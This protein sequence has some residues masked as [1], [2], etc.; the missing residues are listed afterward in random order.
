VDATP[1]AVLVLADEL[2]LLGVHAHHRTV[3]VLV[4]AHLPG[5]VVE[6]GV[7]VRVLAPLGGL[8]VGLQAVPELLKQPAHHELR[9]FLVIVATPEL[10][11]SCDGSRSAGS[12]TTD[13]EA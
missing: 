5:E 13:D 10:F 11:G 7:P 4:S 2:L 8:G 6:L 9:R 3:L 1:P 12:G